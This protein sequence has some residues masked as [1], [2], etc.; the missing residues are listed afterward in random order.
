LVEQGVR[1]AIDIS[2]GLISDLKHV[3]KTSRV[4]A[5]IEVD[6]TP[7]SPAVKVNFEELL[8]L[9]LSGGEDYE[10]LFTGNVKVIDNVKKLVSCPITVIGEIVAE[11]IGEITLVG[12]KGSLIQPGNGGWEHFTAR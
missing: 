5:R 9:A 1:T 4:G 10:L 11:K 3:C 8:E 6:Y 7:I 2:D 12:T